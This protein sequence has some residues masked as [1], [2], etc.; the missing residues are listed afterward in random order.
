M[1]NFK[2]WIVNE[3]KFMQ[4]DKDQQEDVY[5]IADKILKIVISK[6][7]VEEDLYDLYTRTFIKKVLVGE[8]KRKDGRRPVPV[9]LHDYGDNNVVAYYN[10][11]TDEIV[12][13]VR[14]LSVFRDNRNFFINTNGRKIPSIVN[15]L[16][17]ETI[18][19]IDPKLNPQIINPENRAKKASE[20]KQFFSQ[21]NVSSYYKSPEEFDAYGMGILSD[22]KVR[23]HDT[24]EQYKSRIISV[25]EEF[26]RTGN[27]DMTSN[28]INR[29]DYEAL[30]H[31]KTKPTLWRKFQQ[32]LF[33]LLQELK[34]EKAAQAQRQA[35]AAPAQTAQ[36]GMNAQ[37]TLSAKTPK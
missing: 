29:N 6:S 15:A 26:L 30:M 5:L 2:E 34:K 4:L 17:H 9:Y 28:I 16:S 7:R 31:W 36:T 21:G 8:I 10:P 12:M 3:S 27:Y 35:P 37:K 19:A 22:I 25:L 1:L 13:N 20:K 23:F 14:S 33:N 32:R 24:D 11:K 18:H